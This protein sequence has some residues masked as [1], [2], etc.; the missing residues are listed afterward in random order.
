M[1]SKLQDAFL[2]ELVANF[3]ATAM[4]LTRRIESRDTD[5]EIEAL[6][7]DEMRGLYHGVLVV[8]DGGSALAEM[9]LI[10]IIDEDGVAFDSYL[11][12]VCFG[13]WPDEA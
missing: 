2:R 6:V 9:G 3:K 5:A 11:H 8:F 4:R 12:E 13:Y 7:T 10:K 1:T